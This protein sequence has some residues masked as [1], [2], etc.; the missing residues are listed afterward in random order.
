MVLLLH[1]AQ[2]PLARNVGRFRSEGGRPYGA[3]V[4][5]PQDACQE[6]AK[7]AEHIAAIHEDL[8]TGD[9]CAPRSVWTESGTSAEP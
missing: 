3:H 4:A 8:E 5:R 9:R 1:L 7:D 6:A 2:A